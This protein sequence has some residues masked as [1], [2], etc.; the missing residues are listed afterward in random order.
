V[1]RLNGQL[2]NLL[3]VCLQCC[4]VFAEQVSHLCVLIC[5]F[6]HQHRLDDGHTNIRSIGQLQ[7]Q[8]PY[9][10]ATAQR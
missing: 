2:C 3:Y 6:L 10:P 1:Q 8:H 4:W 7:Q 5:H 9:L